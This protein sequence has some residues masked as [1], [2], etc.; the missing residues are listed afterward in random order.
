MGR[1]AINE[2]ENEKSLS[3]RVKKA[4]EYF[5]GKGLSKA[6]LKSA[7][8]SKKFTIEAVEMVPNHI[9]EAPL[10]IK[11]QYT[12]IYTCLAST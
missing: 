8:E 2:V 7:L 1:W 4:I 12:V 6:V 9:N 10:P 11:L 3:K 5:N